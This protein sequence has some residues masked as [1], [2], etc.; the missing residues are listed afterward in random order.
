MLPGVVQGACLEAVAFESLVGWRYFCTRREGNSHSGEAQLEL[1]HL[2]CLGSTAWPW[3]QVPGVGGISHVSVQAPGAC[4]CAGPRGVCV[5]VCE[6]PRCVCAGPRCVC[7][8]TS[9]VWPVPS[10]GQSLKWV[11]L[12][13][14]LAWSGVL[15]S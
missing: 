14:I 12:G 7:L 6:G 13:L 8:C 9:G 11:N 10:Q 4:M 1:W 2:A 3:R 5:C 15:R